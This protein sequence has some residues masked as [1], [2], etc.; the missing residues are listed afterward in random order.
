MAIRISINPIGRAPVAD[1]GGGDSNLSSCTGKSRG[2]VLQ[3]RLE[4]LGKTAGEVS[5][6][7][8]KSSKDAETTERA[9]PGLQRTHHNTTES[10]DDSG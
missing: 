4:L 8:R 6:H 5:K 3:W 7:P 9:M 1:E 2:L 10:V